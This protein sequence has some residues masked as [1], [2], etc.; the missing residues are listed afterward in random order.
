[1]SQSISMTLRDRVHAGL[2]NAAKAEGYEGRSCASDYH[3]D[4]LTAAALSKDGVVLK[5][6]LPPPAED[7]NQGK[8]L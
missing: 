1:M 3:N 6:T 8:L 2:V 4:L 7:P 5:I